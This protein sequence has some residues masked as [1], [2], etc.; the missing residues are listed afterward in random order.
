MTDSIHNSGQGQVGS[1]SRS[2]LS[3]EPALP[4]SQRFLL[5]HANAIEYF[6]VT[7]K[8]LDAFSEYAQDPGY[9]KMMA[10]LRNAVVRYVANPKDDEAQLIIEEAGLALDVPVID[11]LPLARVPADSVANGAWRPRSVNVDLV[12]PDPTTRSGPETSFQKKLNKFSEKIMP[13]V[14]ELEVPGMYTAYQ[15]AAGVAPVIDLVGHVIGD[16]IE[17]ASHVARGWS[18]SI[19]TEVQL[20]LRDIREATAPSGLRVGE[21]AKLNEV[22]QRAFLF[23]ASKLSGMSLDADQFVTWARDPHSADMPKTLVGRLKKWASGGLNSLAHFLRGTA[24]GIHQATDQRGWKVFT[25]HLQFGGGVERFT[26]T[27]RAGVTIMLPTLEQVEREGKA[28]VRIVS[29]FNPVETMFGGVSLTSRGGGMKFRAGPVGAKISEFEHEVK[30]GIPG[31]IGISVGEDYAYGPSVAFGYSPPIGILSALPLPMNIR[32]GGEVTLFHPA[33]R[34]LAQGTRKMAENITIA[35]DESAIFVRKLVGKAAN[36]IDQGWPVRQRWNIA[37]RIT[38]RA[39]S[40]MLSAYDRIAELRKIGPLDLMKSE[41]IKK[42]LGGDATRPLETYGT[43]ATYLEA[44]PKLIEKEALAVRNLA[45]AACRGE[46]FDKK[47][48]GR[49]TDSLTRRALAFEY[50]D[51]LVS[52]MLQTIEEEKEK[53]HVAGAEIERPRAANE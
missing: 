52:A 24:A 50:I 19:A 37:R 32:V 30:A 46:Q 47:S 8:D 13:G 22:E 16:P 1:L 21:L 15:L 9:G 34:P 40:A 51:V 3:N 17:A 42:L 44:L 53:S 6:K 33:L 20:K 23:A 31:I 26:V 41:R 12:D 5:R 2:V 28:V 35:C 14:K 27:T 10:E 29:R 18:D 49:L 36:E 38:E 48:L 11:L 25:V 39:E 4:A 45:S 43:I 7:R